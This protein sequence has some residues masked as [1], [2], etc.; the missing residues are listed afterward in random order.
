MRAQERADDYARAV[1]DAP[2]DDP[3]LGSV[4][5]QQAAIRALELLYPQVTA[6]VEVDLPEQPDMLR[7]LGWEQLDQLARTYLDGGH[8][9]DTTLSAIP[10]TEPSADL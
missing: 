5:R 10:L 9:Q 3:E 8:Q 1:V 6:S 2:L 4:Q 7:D